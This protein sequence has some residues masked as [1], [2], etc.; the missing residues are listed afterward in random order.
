MEH[1]LNLIEDL[2]SQVSSRFLPQY[3]I[4][5]ACCG[6]GVLFFSLINY[7]YLTDYLFKPKGT[8]TIWVNRKFCL[9]REA[10]N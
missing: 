1:R 4:T 7:I 10:L 9:S 6:E 5:L 8:V 2:P 3:V